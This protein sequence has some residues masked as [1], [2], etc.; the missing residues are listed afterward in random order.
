MR[1]VTVSVQTSRVVIT[2]CRGDET[3]EVVIPI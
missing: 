2:I 3:V 1:K